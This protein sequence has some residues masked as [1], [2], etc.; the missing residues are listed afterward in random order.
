[1]AA[2]QNLT[3]NQGEDFRRVIELKDESMALI[4][5]TGYVF[6]GQAR[7]S[8]SDSDASF[9]FGFTLRDQVAD[10]GLVDMIITDSSTSALSI[11]KATRYLYDIEMVDA[12]GYVKRILEGT[13]L[14]NPE[15]TK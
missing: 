2:R 1:M 3:V 15:V 7:L 13:I 6:R 5:L 10:T 11:S 14:L 12:D 4:D 8:Y 9:S